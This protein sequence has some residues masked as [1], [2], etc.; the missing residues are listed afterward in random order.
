MAAPSLESN[1]LVQI[2]NQSGSHVA[3]ARKDSFAEHMSYN[4]THIEA[5]RM[6]LAGP[7]VEALPQDGQP[8]VI[9]GSIMVW[10]ATAGEREML[11]KWLSDNPFAT[12]GVWDLTKMECTP[13][14]CGV[15]KG[16]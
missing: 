1:W 5:G 10:K 16:L 8:P 13:F 6:V 2:P 7:L 3:Q 9:T 14:L 15:R 11:D 4:K 12:S